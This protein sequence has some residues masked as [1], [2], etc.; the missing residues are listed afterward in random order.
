MTTKKN[1]FENKYVFGCLIILTG[2][3]LFFQNCSPLKSQGV[4]NTT[5]VNIDVTDQVSKGAK[6]TWGTGSGTVSPAYQ[7]SIVYTV[8]FASKNLKITVTKGASVT[9]LVSPADKTISDTQ[10]T[11]IKSLL[12][13]IKTATCKTGDMLIGGGS[14]SIGIYSSSTRT[15]PE[16]VIYGSDC[17]GLS[18]SFYQASSGFSELT[19]YLKSL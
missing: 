11:Q 8:D 9:G 13:K 1:R 7:Y 18:S 3:S 16:T 14:D 17:T 10:L 19:T 2:C 4:A 5:A 12:S 6:L 15:S